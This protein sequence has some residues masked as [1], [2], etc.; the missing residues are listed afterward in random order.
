MSSSVKRGKV[1]RTKFTKS[2]CVTI[3]CGVKPGP[4]FALFCRLSTKNHSIREY[5]SPQQVYV[6]HSVASLVVAGSEAAERRRHLLQVER[7]RCHILKNRISWRWHSAEFRCLSQQGIER[8]KRSCCS[9][10]KPVARN[11]QPQK[12]KR[13]KTARVRSR[14]TH[15]ASAGMGTQQFP[16]S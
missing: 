1:L 15:T 8:L 11:S 10:V 4:S 14:R 12:Q 16:S 5:F 9:A 6:A 2:S 3:F 7:P 13:S